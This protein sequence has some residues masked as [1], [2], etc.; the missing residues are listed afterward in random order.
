MVLDILQ[1]NNTEYSRSH[2]RQ[3][4]SLLQ[5][6]TTKMIIYVLESGCND[7]PYQFRMNVI[8]RNERLPLGLNRQ[9][10][11]PYPIIHRI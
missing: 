1:R 7:E 2:I 4:S 5:S 10:V 3:Q 8:A 11:T 6:K 9:L